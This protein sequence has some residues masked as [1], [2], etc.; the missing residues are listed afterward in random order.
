MFDGPNSKG[1]SRK[2]IFRE[3]EGTLKRLQTDYLDLYIIHR[4]DPNT[5]LEETM[6]ALHDLVQ[7]GK[8]RYIGASSMY[9]WQFLKAQTIA[10]E[11]GWTPFISMQNLYNLIYREEER[12]MIPLLKDQKVAMT[13]WS[14]LTKGKLARLD[15]AQTNRSL[16]DGI[17]DRF[18]PES[19]SDQEIIQR[20][21]ELA[22]KRNVS[23]AQIA[24]AWEFSK[25]YVTSVL[26]GSSKIEHI[27]D[28]ISALDITLTKEEID[29]LEE[30]YVPHAK[31]G[32]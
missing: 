22:D 21:R 7:M 16:N 12:E 3:I 13:P 29:Y 27:D 31:A 18:F 24:L 5:P 10:K 6:K 14:P 26:I 30:P 8:V 2:A 28:A 32:F 4:F 1:L 23:P 20:V 17:A 19:K 25:N 9:S 11:N 15:Q